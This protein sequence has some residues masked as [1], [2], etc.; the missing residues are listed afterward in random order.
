[1][2]LNLSVIFCVFVFYQGT[3][4]ST[5]V[6]TLLGSLT[7]PIIPM[8]LKSPLLSCCYQSVFAKSAVFVPPS[9]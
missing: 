5:I 3:V 1:M 8:C 4:V 2:G 6:L 9:D 7:C